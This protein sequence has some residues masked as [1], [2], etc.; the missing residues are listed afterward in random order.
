MC[1]GRPRSA[2]SGPDW[3]DPPRSAPG[4]PNLRHV[5]NALSGG[6]GNDQLFGYGGHDR[7][8]GGGGN[9]TLL[10]YAA[11]NIL[12]GGSGSDVFHFHTALNSRANLDTIQD[13]SVRARGLLNLRRFHYADHVLRGPHSRKV[14]AVRR[15]ARRSKDG[16]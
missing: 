12:S 14:A 13:F 10:S 2:R 1:R 4:S 8:A 7:L 6:G 11:N 3:A 16:R 5:A 9:D 15:I